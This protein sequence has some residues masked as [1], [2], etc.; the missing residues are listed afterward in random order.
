MVGEKLTGKIEM[1]PIFLLEEEI[2]WPSEENYTVHYATIASLRAPSGS[3][4]PYA[5]LSKL[6]L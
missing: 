3:L 6:Q 1:L 2:D 5:T 4:L